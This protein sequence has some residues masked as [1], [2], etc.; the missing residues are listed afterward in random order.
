MIE[1][2]NGNTSA[3]ISETG[4]ELQSLV[5]NGTEFMWN[6]DPAFWSGR[7]PILFPIC[8]GLKD[9][10]YFWN[11][12]KYNLPK[13]GFTRHSIFSAE[14]LSESSAEFTL[15]SNAENK[16]SYPFDWN[17][18]VRYTL[19]DGRLDIEY[20]VTNLSSGVI[21]FSIGAHEAYSCPAGIE[22]YD[23]IFEKEE[24]L[25]SYILDGNLLENN[26]IRILDKGR[27]LPLKY[28]YFEVD[29]LVFKYLKSNSAVLKNR[30]NGRAV[31]LD[32]KDFPYFLLWTA[33]GKEAPYI[34][35][36]P[37]CGIPDSVD[38]NQDILDKEGIIKLDAGESKSFLHT[39]T[40]NKE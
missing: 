3:V 18:K 33:A 23:I 36:E 2:R 25:D 14:K 30:V 38:T 35:L 29:A 26:T 17:L 27:V 37:W 28:Y 20:I 7:A 40:L 8:G 32:F 15:C 1:I 10:A 24:T 12:E 16:K 19:S 11:G 39:I 9:D 31:R 6:G 22:E 13:H 5:Q 4:A 21:P 34:C